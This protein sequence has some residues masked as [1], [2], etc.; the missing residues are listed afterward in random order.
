[1]LKAM[2]I[3]VALAFLPS[4]ACAGEGGKLEALVEDICIGGRLDESLL[5]TM[6]KQVA[7]FYEMKVKELALDDL[8]LAMP[9][10]TSG[11]GIYA[12]DEA[13]IISFARKPANPGTSQSC[14]ITTKTSDTAG[15]KAFVEQKFRSRKMVDETQ[16]S[17]SIIAYELALLGFSKPLYLSVQTSKSTDPRLQFTSVSVYD[18]PNP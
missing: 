17:S 10:A 9:E 2:L 14:T 18:V 5:G 4:A 16:G 13:F 6:V 8:R 3:A 15:I 1:M 7:Q 12:G 11:W